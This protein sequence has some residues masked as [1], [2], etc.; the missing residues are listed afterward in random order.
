M[1][2][3]KKDI[4]PFKHVESDVSALLSPPEA[5]TQCN[6]QSAA[7]VIASRVAEFV[8]SIRHMIC[9]TISAQQRCTTGKYCISPMEYAHSFDRAI[10][11]RVALLISGRCPGS[12]SVGLFQRASISDALVKPLTSKA[13]EFGSEVKF[14]DTR[15]LY[16]INI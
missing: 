6:N 14:P 1:P 16:L 12:S 3:T 15:K 13:R 9:T 7:R 8:Y 10:R 11:S 2:A 4:T 5:N